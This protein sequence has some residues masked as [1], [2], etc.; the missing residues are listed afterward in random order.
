M[1]RGYAAKVVLRT[2]TYLGNWSLFNIRSSMSFPEGKARSAQILVNPARL[3]SINIV[4]NQS[5]T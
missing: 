1:L 5:K 2:I 3:S 4:D